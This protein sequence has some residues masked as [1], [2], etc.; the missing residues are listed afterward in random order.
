LREAIVKACP[1]R[2]KDGQIKN[3]HKHI[4]AAV[5]AD[6]VTVSS[7]TGY[8][9]YFLLHGVEPLLPFDLLEATFMVEGFRSGMTTS[10][11]LALRIQQ[12]SRH[13]S[14][15]AKA[16]DALKAARLNSREQFI[17]RFEHRL[18]KSE[19]SPGD[20]VLVQNSRLEMTVNRFKTH[21]C[22]LGPYEVERRTQGG[23]YKLKELDGTLLRK[24]VAA[25]R[26]Y[27]Y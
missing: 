18:L 14:D 15:L 23:S 22:Y 9:P 6:R 26:L 3:W 16:A 27:P 2:A 10:D 5:F 19:Y 25:F 12:L 8:S 11:L 7:V 20:L 13:A 17:K 4:D 21:P 1:K 24:N